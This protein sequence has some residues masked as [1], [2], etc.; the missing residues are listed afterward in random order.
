M[1]TFA[2]ARGAA[3]SIFNIIDRKPKIDA[4]STGGKVMNFGIKGDIHF[5]NV[6]FNY[7]SRSD[8]SILRGLTTSI[9]AGETVALVGSSGNGKSTC[10]HLLQR[11]YDPLSGEIYIDG[12]NIKHFNISWLRSNIALVGQEPVLFSTTIAENIRYGNPD[13]TDKEVESAAKDS[14]AH[15]FVS[16]LPDVSGLVVNN[17]NREPK[18]KY[19]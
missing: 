19:L 4:M 5:N 17:N 11:F 8:V 3:T 1:E 15:D 18:F 2:A 7:P 12:H 16:K 14:G 13:A 6:V 9:T 10:L